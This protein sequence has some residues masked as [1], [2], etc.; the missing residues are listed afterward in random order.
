MI[1]I[2]AETTPKLYKDLFEIQHNFEVLTNHLLSFNIRMKIDKNLP[3][4]ALLCGDRLV[5]NDIYW[6][7]FQEM[8]VDVGIIA[9]FTNVYHQT[10]ND[11]SL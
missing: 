6:E 9:D 7:A 8:C 2:S 1:I 10:D 4:A 3:I 5:I 11:D